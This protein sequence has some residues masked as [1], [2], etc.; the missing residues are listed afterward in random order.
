[1]QGKGVGGRGRDKR[2]Q[3]VALQSHT[4]MPTTACMGAVR[5]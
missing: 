5:H 1:M 3:S 4:N 2:A